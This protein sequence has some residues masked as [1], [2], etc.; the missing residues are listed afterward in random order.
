MA[1]HLY[2][3]YEDSTGLIV[4]YGSAPPSMIAAQAW[5][6]GTTSIEVSQ[7]PDPDIEYVTVDGNGE[8]SVVPRPP[9]SLT[10][11][12]TTVPAD[13]ATPCGISGIPAGSEATVRG[14]NGRA[15]TVVD[16][17]DLQI[18]FDLAGSYSVTL[19]SFPFIDE[20]IEVTAI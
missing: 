12:S 17:G 5:E 1:V 11:G 3:V 14:P 4:N 19:V 8:A 13:S 15:Q 7:L 6:P 2:V 20:T 18:T 9:M 16:D 10:I